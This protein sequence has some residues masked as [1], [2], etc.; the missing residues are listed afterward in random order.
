MTRQTRPAPA[1]RGLVNPDVIP[2]EPSPATAKS[3]PPQRLVE[4]DTPEPHW[5]RIVSLVVVACFV[6]IEV[7]FWL[8]RHK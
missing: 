8:H 4:T 6:A 1:S 7:W 2:R 5:Q 3:R